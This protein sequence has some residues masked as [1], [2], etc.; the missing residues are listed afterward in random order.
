AAW[1]AVRIDAFDEERHRVHPEP[2]HP[3]LQPERRDLLDLVADQGVADI[4]IGLEP[5]EPVEVPGARG[6]VVGPGLLLLAWEDHAL[7]PVGW[8]PFGPDVPVPVR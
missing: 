2:G 8:L 6:P 3:E 4:E 5:V 7:A 1:A